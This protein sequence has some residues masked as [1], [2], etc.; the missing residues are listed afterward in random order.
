MKIKLF[1]AIS[2]PEGSFQAGDVTDA[3][4]ESTAK[5]LVAGGYALELKQTVEVVPDPKP[6]PKAVV[7]KS[8]KDKTSRK[9]RK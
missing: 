7:I 5:G 4:P 3:L 2:C 1:I 6:E 9:E 8:K